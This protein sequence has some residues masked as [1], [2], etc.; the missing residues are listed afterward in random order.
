MK[1]ASLGSSPECCLLYGKCPLSVNESRKVLQ[2]RRLLTVR[3]FSI[4]GTSAHSSHQFFDETKFVWYTDF[5]PVRCLCACCPM[6]CSSDQD[7]GLG[8]P[9]IGWIS[10]SMPTRLLAR[11]GVSWE[12]THVFA[13]VRAA[14][15]CRHLSAYDTWVIMQS[16]NSK[17]QDRPCT[18]V[19]LLVHSISMSMM[20]TRNLGSS[21]V[22]GGLTVDSWHSSR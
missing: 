21:P 9:G 6:A 22:T 16:A 15:I 11:M 3:I 13:S 20:H 5:P 14:V 10:A 12:A 2:L 4:N 1:I 17:A 18:R 7:N 8:Q 19:V